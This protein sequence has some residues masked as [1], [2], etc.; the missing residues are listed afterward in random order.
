MLLTIL[1]MPI[2]TFALWTPM[3]W[4]KSLILS[5]CLANTCSKAD[6]SFDRRPFARDI[7]SGVGLT[8]SLH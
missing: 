4:M 6:L 3:V 7:A 8:F 5:F 1:A 2:F